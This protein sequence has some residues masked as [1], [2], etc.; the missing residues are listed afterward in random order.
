M[1]RH[2]VPQDVETADK[3]IGFLSLKQFLFVLAGFGGLFL[4]YTFARVNILLALP[5]LPFVFVTFVL[6]LYQRHDQP[7]EVFLASWLKFKFAPK[8]RVWDQEG[9]EQHVIVTAPKKVEID[10]T[11][12]LSREDVYSNFSGLGSKLD[13]RGWSTRGVMSANAQDL[14]TG[15]SERLISLKEVE[16]LKQKYKPKE[17]NIIDVFDANNSPIATR[18]EVDVD[19]AAQI[20]NSTASQILSSQPLNLINDDG[21]NQSHIINSPEV[22][23]KVQDLAQS[24]APLSTISEQAEA[25]IS[26]DQLEQGAE[27]SLR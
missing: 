11:K 24:D 19:K 1:A 14:G 12:G 20:A 18:V 17:S 10:Y 25:T 9:Y 13:T 22:A 23:Q 26:K 5:F 15:E 7:V 27:F 3:L 8:T 4:A 2:T 21:D 16:A 6:G